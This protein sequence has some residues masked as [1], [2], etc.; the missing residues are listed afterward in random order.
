MIKKIKLAVDEAAR[1]Q[2]A[3]AAFDPAVLEPSGLLAR[4]AQLQKSLDNF[5]TVSCIDFI[6]LMSTGSP[7][8][9]KKFV[10]FEKNG[11]YR[12]IMQF[13]EELA[14]SDWC[15]ASIDESTDVSDSQNAGIC[16]FFVKNGEASC[17]H[18]IC[19]RLALAANEFAAL[20]SHA[21]V[22]EKTLRAIRR[23][24]AFSS[25]RKDAKIQEVNDE[26]GTIKKRHTVRWLSRKG[27]LTS[28]VGSFRRVLDFVVGLAAMTPNVRAEA[29]GQTDEEFVE[30]ADLIDQMEAP[31]LAHVGGLT[32]PQLCASLTSFKML[33]YRDRILR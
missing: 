22:V 17:A 8:A 31:D 18:C 21:S 26:S 32:I 2:L 30:R 19:H 16:V 15:A 24:F 13:P 12:A 20:T 14:E 28:V 4:A 23:I 10:A 5:M 25:K 6:V 27:A 11:H 29:L 33:A 1:L 3:E 9:A 7:Y